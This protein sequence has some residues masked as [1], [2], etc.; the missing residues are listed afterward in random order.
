MPGRSFATEEYSTDSYRYGFNGKENDSETGTQDYGLRIYNPGLGK[1]LSVDPLSS[2]YPWNSTYAFAENDI[3]RCSDLD[4]A[5]KND[6]VQYYDPLDEVMK[7]Y[8]RQLQRSPSMAVIE[9]IGITVKETYDFFRRDAWQANTW[10][11][12]GLF[13]EEIILTSSPFSNV[14]YRPNTPRLDAL[15]ADFKDKVING[16][17]YSRTKYATTFGLNLMTAIAGS[18]GINAAVKIGG[19]T[20]ITRLQQ[21]NSFFKGVNEIKVI[22]KSFDEVIDGAQNITVTSKS[23]TNLL[24]SGSAQ[25]AWKSLMVKH[26]KTVKD[27]TVSADGSTFYFTEQNTTYALF[28]QTSK[29]NFA[30]MTISET[31]VASDG[32]KSVTKARFTKE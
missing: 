2:E 20:A 18:K 23:S 1:F 11:N 5:E 21:F 3:I 12:A 8:N 14:T 29:G 32:V 10:I 9:S 25:D 22:A 26:G 27:L 6:E 7:D 13:M 17:T 30:T 19:A 16:D 31:K 24:V 4:G 15:N 28:S